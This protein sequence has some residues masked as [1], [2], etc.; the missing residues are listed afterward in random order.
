M[1]PEERSAYVG[2]KTGAGGRF[3]QAPSPH[4]KMKIAA[5]AFIGNVESLFIISPKQSRTG[6]S[7]HE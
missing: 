7:L 2:F 3:P 5:A 6:A 4:A 1:Q